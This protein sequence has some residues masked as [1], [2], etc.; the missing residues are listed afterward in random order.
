MNPQLKER[1]EKIETILD[2]SIP[3]KIDTIWQN[4][5]FD[6]LPD[7]LT[8]EYLLELIKPGRELMKRGGKRWRPLLSILSCELAGGKAENVYPLIPLIELCHTASL[9]HDDIE[10]NSDTRRGGK[11][12]H[13]KYGIGEAINAGSWLY[14]HA[15]NYV[16]NNRIDK[17]I[18]SIAGKFYFHNLARLHLGQSMDIGWHSK[19]DYIPSQKEY[20]AMTNLKTGSLAKL[21]GEIGFIAAGKS[22]SEIRAY[23][24][25]MI[26][27]GIGFQILDDVKNIT[28]GNFGKDRGDDIVEGKKSLP[29]IIFIKENPSKKEKLKHL[30]K[31]AAN[32]GINS[33]AVKEAIEMLLSSGAAAEAEKYAKEIVDTALIKLQNT[34]TKNEAMNLIL[35]LFGNIL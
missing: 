35:E 31:K 21:A 18:Q 9:I 4:I 1:L 32:E 28:R 25:L 30:F 19:E 6:T 22:E 13:L 8:S 24:N 7:G 17:E 27:F 11:A 20:I 29:V 2:F 3:E 12:I 26:D 23:G 14:F 5:S 16:L 15:A 33:H 10:D 34:Y